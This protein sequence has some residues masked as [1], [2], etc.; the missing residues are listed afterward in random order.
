MQKL[1]AP[2]DQGNAASGTGNC[3]G[4]VRARGLS[5]A[6]DLTQPELDAIAFAAVA[7][8]PGQ[9]VAFEQM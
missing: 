8:A 1:Y 7:V 2:F 5:G 3:I 6:R 9:R 4:P